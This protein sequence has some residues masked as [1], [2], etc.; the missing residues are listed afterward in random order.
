M[1]H[2]MGHIISSPESLSS[3]FILTTSVLCGSTQ[4]CNILKARI[5]MCTSSPVFLKKTTK[6]LDQMEKGTVP[7]GKENSGKKG[8][9]S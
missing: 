2:G 9:F 8:A 3:C 4:D 5:M 6:P 1:V 7:A